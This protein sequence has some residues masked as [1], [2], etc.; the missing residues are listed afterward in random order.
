MSKLDDIA[1]RWVNTKGLA[2]DILDYAEENNVPLIEDIS[3][4][5]PIQLIILETI[6]YNLSF[7]LMEAKFKRMRKKEKNEDVDSHKG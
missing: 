7:S 3:S 1:K 5:Y 6:H 4:S 2:E